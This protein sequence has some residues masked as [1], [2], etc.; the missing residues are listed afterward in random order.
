MTASL[1]YNVNTMS[2]KK[3]FFNV[4]YKFFPPEMVQYWKRNDSARAKVVNKPDGSLGMKIEGEKYVYPSFPRGPVLMGSLSKIKHQIRMAFNETRAILQSLITEAKYEMI[5]PERM[6]ASVRELW[7][8]FEKLENAEV[9]EDMK[10]RIKLYKEVICMLFQ[11]DD[12][13]RM[14]WQWLMEHIDMKKVRLT[15]EDKYYFRGKYFKVDND[16]FDY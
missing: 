3:R 13:Y 2:I 11:E 9:T 15:K 4:W 5:P 14:R 7:Y 10:G 8:A 16:R 6:T 1:S 12:A